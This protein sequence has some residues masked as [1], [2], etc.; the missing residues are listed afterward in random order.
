MKKLTIVALM[1]VLI[2]FVTHASES[3]EPGPAMTSSTPR[4]FT[5]GAVF[6]SAGAAE[7]TIVGTA[8]DEGN[9]NAAMSQVMGQASTKAGALMAE[10]ANVNAQPRKTPVAVS[11]DLFTVLE[12][13]RNFSTFTDSAFD[14]TSAPKAEGFKNYFFAPNW[15][16]LKLN[17]KNQT[18]AI[19]SDTLEIDPRTFSIMLRG[20]LADD[21][22]D[23]LYKAGWKNVHVS[24]GNVTRS[25]GHDI[26]TPWRIRLDAPTEAETGK[27]AFRAYEYSV[28]DVA[29][30]MVSPRLFPQG[31]VDPRTRTLV[32]DPAVINALVF[33]NDAATATAYAIATYAKSAVNAQRGANFITARSEVKG[34][35]I[36]PDGTVIT[37][38]KMNM[39]KPTYAETKTLQK[40]EAKTQ[41][42]E[43]SSQETKDKT[44]IPTE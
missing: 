39:S 2:P 7:L 31:I 9:A 42:L 36:A 19:K 24:I 5:Q 6:P 21:I 29:A 23:S 34:I 20:F 43:V 12:R 37:S 28:S 33:A 32:T 1:L 18:V 26:H 22:I 38:A 8:A 25:V 40:T 16:K 35:L 13:C 3:D 14:I 10:V 15:R 4:Q 41:K 27:Y 17:K 44:V 30:A 11:K